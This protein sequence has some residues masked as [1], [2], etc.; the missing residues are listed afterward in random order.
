MCT[1]IFTFSIKNGKT[2]DYLPN[3][4]SRSLNLSAV[5]FLYTKQ[6][7]ADIIPK[8]MKSDYYRYLRKR[9]PSRESLGKCA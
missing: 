2:K 6:W 7:L 3:A 1:W 8:Y 5:N 4:S 9:T